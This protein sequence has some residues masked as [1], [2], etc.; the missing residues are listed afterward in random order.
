LRPLSV[1]EY[2]AIQTFPSWFEFSGRVADKYRQIGNA[3]PVHFGEIVG[4]HLAAFDERRLGP[5]DGA[6]SRL[7]RYVGTDH[8]SW[9]ER[10]A[11]LGL[12]FA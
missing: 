3:V 5:G 2:A 10:Q 7:S 4:R 1:E 11:S 6:S 8:S 9:A 12:Q